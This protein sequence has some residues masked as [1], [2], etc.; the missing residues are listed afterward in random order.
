M[1]LDCSCIRIVYCQNR[2][3]WV[4]I[5]ASGEYT[6][7]TGGIGWVYL[8][9]WMVYLLFGTLNMESIHCQN[10]RGWV[11]VFGT[12]Y[13]LFATLNKES[14]LPKQRGVGGCF[15]VFGIV[16]VLFEMVYLVFE[17]VCL[18]FE[19]VYLLFGMVY[20]LFEMVHFF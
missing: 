15:L 2:G 6:A 12:V 7:K 13:M 11:G 5:L 3:G 9:F 17:M 10:K 19:M 20:L 8:V 4:G 16:Y 14:I 18:L 1:A